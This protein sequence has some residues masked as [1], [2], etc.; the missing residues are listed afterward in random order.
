MYN[1]PVNTDCFYVM[2]HNILRWSEQAKPTAF[3]HFLNELACN[4]CLLWHYT[5]NINC[6]KHHLL[7]LWEKMLHLHNWINKVI[8]QHCSWNGPLMSDWFCGS[9]PPDCNWCQEIALKQEMMRKWWWGISR[10][11][12]NVVLYREENPKGDIIEEMAE[13]DLGTDSEIVFVMGT[14]L[15]MPEVTRLVTELCC[16]VKI[17]GG[18]IIWINR[19]AL[20]SGLKLLLDLILHRDCNEVVFLLLS[21]YSFTMFSNWNTIIL[22]I[23]CYRQIENLIN[24]N[25]FI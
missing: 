10:L 22:N 14:A 23:E 13:Q 20:L 19:D 18:L 17:Q 11:H 21:W 9:E 1:S 24:L 16:A 7:N 4:S 6:I 8:C 25:I 12:L 5:Q 15:K 2:V 3:H